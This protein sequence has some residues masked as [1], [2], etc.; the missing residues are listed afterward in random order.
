MYIQSSVQE[1]A[2]LGKAA[3]IGIGLPYDSSSRKPWSPS[4]TPWSHDRWVKGTGAAAGQSGCSHALGP[5]AAM[6]GGEENLCFLQG[7]YRDI[8]VVWPF[9]TSYRPTWSVGDRGKEAP[10]ATF[11]APAS[12]PANAIINRQREWSG[13]VRVSLLAANQP[14]GRSQPVNARR[15]CL[16]QRHMRRHRAS[17]E[18]RA[19]HWRGSRPP[20]SHRQHGEE[21]S[22]GPGVCSVRSR[23]VRGQLKASRRSLPSL[24]PTNGWTL[25][26][27]VERGAAGISV[28]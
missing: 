10:G 15:N 28:A 23:I 11:L 3:A 17:D 8:R 12:Q 7:R 13:Q 26:G 18:A 20:T 14:Q 25:G 1:A 9:R 27:T 5:R 2:R 24:S 21:G 19:L 6:S 4:F 22:S 16:I